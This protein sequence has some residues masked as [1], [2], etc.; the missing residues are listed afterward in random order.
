MKLPEEGILLRIFIGETDRI[1][2]KALYEQIVLTGA[3]YAK[4]RN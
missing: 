2:D 1:H 3:S 4:R